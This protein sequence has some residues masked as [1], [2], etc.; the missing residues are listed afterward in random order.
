MTNDPSN[1]LAK[2][3]SNDLTSA[4]VDSSRPVAGDAGATQECAAHP[5]P[6]AFPD[7]ALANSEESS[8]N[9][10]V[11]VC[12]TEAN[13]HVANE[14][15][16]AVDST[17]SV[18]V[19]VPQVECGGPQLE[20]GEPGR[21]EPGLEEQAVP[22]TCE[23]SPTAESAGSDCQAAQADSSSTQLNDQELEAAL[24]QCCSRLVNLLFA[25]RMASS[26]DLSA[27]ISDYSKARQEVLARAQAARDGRDPLIDLIHERRLKIVEQDQAELQS[28]GVAA[29]KHLA[30][31]E[32][33]STALDALVQHLASVVSG[34]T[35]QDAGFPPPEDTL[36][37]ALLNHKKG[38][39][40]IQRMIGRVADRRKDLS[41]ERPS[42]EFQELETLVGSDDPA[43]LEEF[44]TNWA[45]S[46]L[47][48]RQSRDRVVVG[49]RDFAENCRKGVGGLA[50][51]LLPAIDG[52]DSGLASEPA[53]RQNWLTAG[54]LDGERRSLV[55][56]WF[57]SYAVLCQHLDKFL[58][59]A[60]LE[61]R[62]VD[63]GVPFD[64]ETMEPIGTVSHAEFP[65]DSVAA[66]VRRGFVLSGENLR[67]VAVEVVRNS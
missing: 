1:E 62:V 19:G 49:L 58:L 27:A 18:E 33:L 31:Y 11:Q 6:V 44:V 52:V 36:H 54:E 20:R 34:M 5:G 4:Q 32:R 14:S 60:G 53:S 26:A 35:E 2:D 29:D 17:S 8:W 40:I 63:P 51:S 47:S 43:Q 23:T 41:G 59:E 3:A 56:R 57:S 16:S 39:E 38:L 24:A 22:P 21:G 12:E 67:P 55:E 7:P 45:K 25:P 48:D 50:K 10:A 28:A 61:S 30:A 13:A 15:Q 46:L 66:V 42:G 9:D 64:P 37:A 65:D